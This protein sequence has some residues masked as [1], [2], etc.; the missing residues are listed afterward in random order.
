MLPPP[1]RANEFR[2]GSAGGGTAGHTQATVPTPPQQPAGFYVSLVAVSV[3]LLMVLVA[4]AA[5]LPRHGSMLLCLLTGL[6][7]C[8]LSGGAGTSHRPRPWPEPMPQ[9]HSPNPTPHTAAHSVA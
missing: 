4:G 5:C 8:R 3:M 9:P 6:A 1:R 2:H 7:A